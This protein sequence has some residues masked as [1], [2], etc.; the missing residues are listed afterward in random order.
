MRRKIAIFIS[1]LGILFFG[2]GAVFLSVR[3]EKNRNGVIN[4]SKLKAQEAQLKPTPTLQTVS[5]LEGNSASTI[6]ITHTVRSGETLSV[7]A[8]NYDVNSEEIVLINSLE[9]PDMLDVGQE[10]II[11]GVRPTV[12]PDPSKIISNELS[13][14]IVKK[15]TN[16]IVNGL[17]EASFI[18]MPEN[19]R[20]HALKIF[21]KGQ[22]IGRDQYAFSIVGDSTTEIPFFLARFDNGPY[23]LGEYE[24][25][26]SV[27]SNFKGSYS[28]DSVAVRVGLHSYTL[29][30]PIWADKTVCLPNEG[31]FACEIRLHNPSI[32]ILRL[33]SNDVGVSELFDESMRQAVQYAIDNGVI[34]IIGTKA[35]RFEGSNQNNEILRSIATDFQI[36]LWDFDL[37]AGT[38]DGR[39]LDVDNVHMTTY[40]PHDYTQ[41]EAFQRGHSMHNLTAL[42]MLDTI[43]KEVIL[44]AKG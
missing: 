42:M 13:V 32:I 17:S 3:Q 30:D 44:T 36:P 37:V 39:G 41:P 12:T 38:I 23:E 18:I 27:I 20:Q 10:L 26:E 14:P 19:V 34:P 25:L 21:K 9:N 28:R 8:L 5:L 31:V 7:I 22:D 11:P 43:W 6:Q 16:V 15:P 1:I 40:Y 2:L 29:F 35:D 33:G 24:Y 4:E